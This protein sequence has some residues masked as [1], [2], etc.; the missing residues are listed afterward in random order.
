[1]AIMLALASPEL[2]VEGL[3][4]VRRNVGVEQ[5]ARNALTIL[6]IAGHADS[7]VAL[8]S[9]KPVARSFH[10]HGSSGQS[11]HNLG[12]TVL[13]GARPVPERRAVDFLISRITPSA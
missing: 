11:Q 5:C 1:M 3:T 8:G 4:A 9:D 10:S 6:E 7:P 12:E 13:S 2:R